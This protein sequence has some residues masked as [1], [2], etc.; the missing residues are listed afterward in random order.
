MHSRGGTLAAIALTRGVKPL[1]ILGLDAV[2]VGLDSLCVFT[3]RAG[4]FAVVTQFGRPVRVES[5]P[6]LK[7]KLP[8]PVQTVARFDGRLFALVPPPREFLTLGKRNV[9]A[10]GLILWKVRDPQKFMQTVFDRAGA[11]SR[12]ADILFAEL[13]AA[14]G[15]AA[16][17]AFVSTAPG[18]Y[19]A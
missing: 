6:G 4:E 19:Q 12:L 5:A 13:G 2:L 10:S 15:S 3:V 16:F 8:A 7:L 11:E 14:L 18:E 9:V 1:V 17:P